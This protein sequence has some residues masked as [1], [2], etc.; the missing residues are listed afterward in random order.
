[1]GFEMGLEVDE[2]MRKAESELLVCVCVCKCMFIHTSVTFLT[3]S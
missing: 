3:I 2:E 1:M